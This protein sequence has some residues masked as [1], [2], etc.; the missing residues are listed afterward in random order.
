MKI[1]MHT[2]IA[3]TLEILYQRA[4][5]YGLFAARTHDM[6]SSKLNKYFILLLTDT[7]FTQ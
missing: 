3:K 4:S 2:A 5:D 7:Y 1:R 6:L